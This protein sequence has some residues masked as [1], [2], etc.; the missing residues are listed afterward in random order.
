MHDLFDLSDTIHNNIK[1]IDTLLGCA[2][3]VIP[4][5]LRLEGILE[6]DKELENKIDNLEEIP[7]GSE[8]EVEI[9]A[10]T[11]YVIEYV[12]NKNDKNINSITW[13]DWIWNYFRGKGGIAHRTDTIFY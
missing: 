4:R 2:D 5:G 9:R 1:N 11:L 12:K 10:F 6:Y 7:Q 3:Y 8:Y 13:D